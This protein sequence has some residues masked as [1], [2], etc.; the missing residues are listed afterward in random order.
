VLRDISG[1]L[2]AAYGNG[3]DQESRIGYTMKNVQRIP[4]DT[5]VQ[6]GNSM[7]EM[8]GTEPFRNSF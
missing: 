5:P 4:G 7:G 6:V 8:Y 2:S 1:F 3:S